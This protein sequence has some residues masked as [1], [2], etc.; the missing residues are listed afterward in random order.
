[1]S[2]TVYQSEFDRLLALGYRLVHVSGY[3]V[4]GAER[5]AAIW[6]RRSGPE[7]EARHGMTAARYQDEFD[8]LVARGFRLVQV[9]GYSVAGQE[10]YAAIWERSAGEAWSARHGLTSQA[11]QSAFDDHVRRGF[12]LA[13]V[14]AYTAGGSERYAAIWHAAGDGGEGGAIDGRMAAYL[15]QQ[16]LPGL[17]LAIAKDGRLVYARGFGH[18]DAAGA[19]RVDA[20][21]RFRI[22]SVSKPLTA[23][24]I[25]RLVEQGRLS[26]RKKVFGRRGIL[27]E[28]Y[29]LRP[30]GKRLKKITVRH[31][32]EHTSGF[33]SEGGDPMFA[34]FDLDQHALVSWV[35]DNQPP[36][37][38]PGKGYAYS[39]FG[40]LLLG[41]IIEQVTG[42]PYETFVTSELL[43]PAGIGSMQVAGDTLADRAPGEVAYDDPWGWAYAMRV[44][45]MDAHG[46]WIATP[47]DL[48]RLLVRVDGSPSKPDLLSPASLARMWSGSAANPGYGLGWMLLSDGVGHNGAM[49]GSLAFLVQRDDGF[50]FAVL[51]NGRPDGDPY[52]FELKAAIEDAI[53][54]V[55]SWPGDDLF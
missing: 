36:R 24:A 37:F 7:W 32:L 8:A 35:L 14:S 41:R 53:A 6:E 13:R 2:P 29:G 46:G 48:L 27:G 49:P 1:M 26:L 33:S 25:L 52:G 50:A 31:L 43:T 12:R 9:S 42:L 10:R 23:I 54:A 22:A 5:Y 16:G 18:A 15:A 4:A 47:S 45:R 17:S 11:Y 38:K 21:H 20:A 40:Y 19:E 39:N 34:H 44:S 28:Q 30:Y 51:A 3:E 55:E